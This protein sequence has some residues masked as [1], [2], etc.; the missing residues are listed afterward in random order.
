MLKYKQYQQNEQ[1]PLTLTHRNTHTHTPTHQHTHR[2]KNETITTQWRWNSITLNKLEKIVWSKCLEEQ[3]FTILNRTTNNQI[4]NV[5]VT[6][7]RATVDS[8]N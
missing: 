4:R 8:Q 7:L 5:S 6:M 2:K 1:S 3:W